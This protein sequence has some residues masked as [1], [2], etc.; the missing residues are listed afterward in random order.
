MTA[1]AA[2]PQLSVVIGSHDAR[3][4]LVQC[5]ASVRRG[6]AEPAVE[7]LVADNSTDGT[8]EFVR[9]RFPDVELLTLPARALVPELW[10]AGIARSR[11]HIVA[12]TSA[13]CVPATDWVSRVIEAHAT[14]VAAV[15]GAIKPD[16][17]AGAV[18]WAIYFCRYSRYMLPFPAGPV[19]DL[20]GDNAS[21]KR[22][23][24]DACQS[25]WRN[26]F[27]E[28]TVHAAIR[29]A[30]GRLR[31][32]PTVVV[33]H[34]GV[35]TLTGFLRQRVRH[36]HAFGRAR[37]LAGIRRGLY[38]L[39]GPAIPAL[40]LTRIVRGVTRRR[41]YR[42]ALLRA[43]PALTLFLTGWAAGELTGYLRGPAA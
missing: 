14:D 29:Q 23:A 17:A 25:A 3:P 35:S 27:W 31:L 43:L 32:D 30:G 19:D 22:L 18:Q 41:R 42:R 38:A 8:A 28:P 16:E 40:L 15:G 34:R 37:E 20:A 9:E 39:A 12:I 26:G 2:R 21:Y 11:G 33:H 24:L 10:A 36:G 5:L 1:P 7:I 6:G 13:Q 4:S